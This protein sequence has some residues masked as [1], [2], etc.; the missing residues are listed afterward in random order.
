VKVDD[1]VL[2]GIQEWLRVYAV[3][4]RV[5]DELDGM[6]L[7]EITHRDVPMLA[8]LERL[9][10]Q[11]AKG[12]AALASELRATAR[13]PVGRDRDDVE[14]TLDEVSK[15]RARARNRYAESETQRITTRS[16]PV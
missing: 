14:T 13:R 4:T 8:R 1:A 16:G 10:R 7:E 15:I 2:E 5:D 3:V 6:L 11:L 12:N 9:L